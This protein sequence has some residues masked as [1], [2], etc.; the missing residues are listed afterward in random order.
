[1]LDMLKNIVTESIKN[2]NVVKVGTLTEI[3]DGFKQVGV[4][5]SGKSEYNGK[6]IPAP[7]LPE[8][9]VWQW[10]MSSQG[11]TVEPQSGSPCITFFADANIDEWKRQGGVYE[12]GS[13]RSHDLR[14]GICLPGGASPSGSETTKD[15]VNIYV[16]NGDYFFHIDKDGHLK[17]KIKSWELEIEEG[18]T[19]TDKKAFSIKSDQNITIEGTTGV[20]N[21]APN[22]VILDTPMVLITG[23]I[24]QGA[25]SAM[26]KAGKAIGGAFEAIFAGTMRV[27]KNI[28]TNASIT[29]TNTITAGGEITSST[30]VRVGEIKLKEHGHGGV[31]AGGANT[32]KSKRIT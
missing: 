27:E 22:N 32:E 24:I 30:E 14:D 20:T 15:G 23:S 31:M 10:T 17:M 6:Q 1:M 26:A 18:T 16:Q 8:V 5:L 9:P 3:G 2:T 25:I 29:A 28:T 11:I 7:V 12:A 21:K 19:I 13:I 4:N